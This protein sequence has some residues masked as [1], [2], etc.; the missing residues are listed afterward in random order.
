MSSPNHEDSSNSMAI[1][2][3]HEDNGIHMLSNLAEYFA[4][5]FDV[6]LVIHCTDMFNMHFNN[7]INVISVT[8]MSDYIKTME[9][10]NLSSFEAA[11]FFMFWP[12]ELSDIIHHSEPKYIF[13]A[14]MED[15]KRIYVKKVCDAFVSFSKEGY[16]IYDNTHDLKYYAKVYPN[17]V[18]AGSTVYGIVS[19]GNT[20][21][22]KLTAAMF[23]L[24]SDQNISSMNFLT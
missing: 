10:I 16:E 11:F 6:T 1:F 8:S 21:S 23:L 24:L 20:Q 22:P 17:E 18:A 14:F 12:N 9:G 3:D 7:A 5:C 2:C 4:T 15:D 13:S 19:Y